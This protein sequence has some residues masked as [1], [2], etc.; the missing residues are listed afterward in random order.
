MKL[1][2]RAIAPS[3]AIPKPPRHT[4]PRFR[5]AIAAAT[6]A[7]V[8]AAGVVVSAPAAAAE[9]AWMN[10]AL[11]SDERADLLA[12]AM[13]F[14]QKL[15]LFAGSGSGAVAIPELGIPARREIDG[16]TGVILAGS[17]T[18][19]F[20]AGLSLASTWNPERARA[21]GAQAG[22]EAH[23][24]GFS[25]WA[26]PAA[27]L[28]RNPFHGRQWATFG[29]DPLL[30]GLIP[31]AVVE[32]VN[33]NND[34]DGVYSLTKHFVANNQET[35]RGIMDTIVDERTLRELYV[36][37][38]EPIVE[39]GP[40]A[41]M[42]AYPRV[43]GSK[44]CE[45]PG[46]LWDT[47]KGEL[48]F[49]G[50]VSSDF[51]ACASLQ[52]YN[53]GADVCGPNFPDLDTLRAAVQNG[54]I[55]A[56]RFDDM[57]HRV[58]RTYFEH[59]LIDN[60]PPGS[61][62]N[63]APA[64]AP[65][66]AALI[67]Q[68]R[69]AAYRVAVDGSV[70]LRNQ[71]DALPLAEDGVDSI[72]V[73]GEGADRYIGGFG[74]DIVVNPTS[75]TTIV[76]G[77]AA[78]AGAAVDVTH[79]EGWDPV[80]PGDLLPG[81]QPIPSGVLRAA[82]GTTPGL[83]GEWFPTASFSGSPATTR[84]DDQVNWGQGLTGLLATFGYETSP[85]PKL[86][87]VATFAGGPTATRWT[88]TLNPTKTGTY[89]LG[90]TA[91]GT[92]TM[93]IDGQQVLTADADTLDT[94]S[95]DRQL[96]AGETY[97]IRIDYVSDAPNQC[98]NT[99]G[100]LGTAIRL[101][102]TPPSAAASPQIVEA[103]AAAQASDVAVIVAND[104]L[105]ESLDRGSLRLSQNEDLLIKAVTDVNPRTIVV[106]TTGGAV[107]MPWLE[108]AEAVIQAWYPGQEQGRAVASLLFG[109]ENFTGKLPI[110]WPAST[111]QVTDEL[112]I[113]TP[114]YDVNNPNTTV[115]FTEGVNIGYRGYDELGIDPLFEFG[116]G[117]SYTDFAYE[118]VEVVDPVARSGSGPDT[119]QPGLVRV[120][121]RNTGTVKGTETVHLYN[122]PLPTDRVGTPPRQLLG[123]GQITLDP[124]ATGTVEI[125]VELYSSAHKLAYWDAEWNYWITPTGE[126]ELF[127][128]ASSRDVRLTDAITVTEP[129]DAAP[130]VSLAAS[131]A[132]PTGNA[133]WYR[134]PVQLTATAHDDH[135][136]APTVEASVDGGAYAAVSAP[137]VVSSDGTHTVTFRATDSNGNVSDVASWTGKVDRTAPAITATTQSGGQFLA[138][139]ASDAASGVASLE[140]RTKLTA[141]G[142]TYY[143]A[144]TA[145]S[146]PI[147][148]GSGM[149]PSIQYRA[150]DA[151]GNVTAI[152]PA[153]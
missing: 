102:W 64:A 113:A 110:T 42:C 35:A 29:E 65:L 132:A 142:H 10:T 12:A 8:I 53:L 119:S 38:W 108:S 123:W 83:T 16:A 47:L 88:G 21:F 36:R 101:N 5:G 94:F 18:T 133:D 52:A 112:G 143:S 6:A 63:P 86:P 46:L 91:L 99:T 3:S 70:L 125:P 25:G 121:V 43:N 85:A 90:F 136:A 41:V 115:E 98:C 100:N 118:S 89:G 27:D 87:P 149:V 13:T 81:A 76:D 19:A 4:T 152:L 31:A 139:T 50:W 71:A 107:E 84:I 68:G 26:G 32:G 45:N 59:G 127:V 97:D 11:S 77:I 137:V 109:D 114:V 153:P 128:G 28:Q 51:N 17:P 145:Y 135:D 72:A 148:V 49:P 7:A 9:P 54:T 37:Q 131:P 22:A 14:E 130:T 79:V 73:I 151:A 69:D 20:P 150:T 126:T 140:Y 56:S 138:L 122:G 67:A 116:Y 55:S 106:L 40:G 96:E 57:V 144:W 120:Q 82:D 33:E 95:I 1:R 92:A 93:W 104:Y 103:V 61:L 111:A 23:S 146:A 39:A 105:G 80:R 129:D 124:G 34:T 24:L 78:R 30:A 60:P 44:A 75:V 58:L 117:L 74:S 48:A 2:A 15:T 141:G 62:Q 66:P 134:D 147:P